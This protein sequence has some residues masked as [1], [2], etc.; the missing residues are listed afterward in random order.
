MIPVQESFKHYVLR[1]KA[2]CK[3]CFFFRSCILT[4]ISVFYEK[5]KASTTEPTMAIITARISE[6]V[7]PFV[8]NPELI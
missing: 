2:A 3:V 1:K 5:R 7:N 8:L 6:G 4:E